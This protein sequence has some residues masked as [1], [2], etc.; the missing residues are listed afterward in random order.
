MPL[1]LV[2]RNFAEKLEMSSESKHQI[3]DITEEI[4][5]HWLYSF[6]SADG[7]KTYCLYE[8]KDPQQ[9]LEHAEVVGIPADTIVEVSRFW[10]H[11]GD[12][13]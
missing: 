3:R 4:G 7:K 13:G 8:A 1:Y 5:A 12:T 9:L 10:P 11:A 2:E 6:L